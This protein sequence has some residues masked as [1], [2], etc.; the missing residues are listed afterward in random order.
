MITPMLLR[1]ALLCPW[2]VYNVLLFLDNRKSAD[3][4]AG[5]GRGLCNWIIFTDFLG[6]QY[7]QLLLKHCILST[8]SIAEIT[9]SCPASA[10]T[11]DVTDA[12]VNTSIASM[13]LCALLLHWHVVPYQ[14]ASDQFAGSMLCSTCRKATFACAT[15][16][17]PCM[18]CQKIGNQLA[19]DDV[20][21]E[22]E[23]L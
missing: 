1:D 7:W 2:P 10:S 17:N 18:E 14:T 15:P 23:C 21:P 16:S 4:H 5:Y 19:I 11:A 13:R 12:F 8:S 9:G 6:R 22:N 20:Q 3:G